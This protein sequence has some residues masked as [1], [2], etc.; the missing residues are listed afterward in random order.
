MS[1]RESI[2]RFWNFGFCLLFTLILSVYHIYKLTCKL[3]NSLFLFSVGF[4]SLFSGEFLIY[5][6]VV[7]QV[8]L[9]LCLKLHQLLL[10][11][12]S[13]FCQPSFLTFSPLLEYNL[14]F[15]F[16]FSL[17]FYNRLHLNGLYQFITFISNLRLKLYH[18]SNNTQASPVCWGHRSTVECWH[19]IYEVLISNST[20]EHRK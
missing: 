5:L 7:Q 11:P 9:W 16:D 20:G 6:W 8:L 4:D 19:S 13:V 2:L 12:S 14:K 17:I 1:T 18:F 10:S 15:Y 3:L